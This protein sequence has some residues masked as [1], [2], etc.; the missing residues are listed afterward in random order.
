MLSAML[1]AMLEKSRTTGKECLEIL[2]LFRGYHRSISMA[3]VVVAL[4]G[5]GL[6]LADSNFHH[7]SQY[8][9]SSIF[10]A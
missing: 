6:E 3:I 5:I 1:S 4:V 10:S 9:T 2:T 8:L 7:L